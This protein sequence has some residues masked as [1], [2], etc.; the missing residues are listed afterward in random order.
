MKRSASPV[1]PGSTS[2][3]DAGPGFSDGG[4]TG[5]LDADRALD[6]MDGLLPVSDRGPLIAHLRQCPACECAFQGMV[7]DRERQRATLGVGLGF[8]QTPPVFDPAH[9]A[10]T[11]IDRFILTPIRR[12]G[13]ALRRPMVAVPA[14][15]AAVLLLVFL[16]SAHRPQPP[17]NLA[18][19][20]RLP[21]TTDGTKSLAVE[22]SASPSDLFAGLAAYDRGEYPQAIRLLDQA[23]SDGDQELFR[24]IYL[25][26]ALLRVGQTKQAAA[27]MG[28]TSI[29]SLLLLPEPW[30][31]GASLTAYHAYAGA[32]MVA[33]AEALRGRLIREGGAL[34]ELARGL[35]K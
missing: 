24:R 19:L 27:V 22:R 20:P 35:K 16:W 11:P 9:S 1:P 4:A 2:R 6:L 18:L 29:Q 34:E 12:A 30:R 26:N 14:G 33:Q 31:S 7:A 23:G 17:A 3:D 28:S 13:A 8:E 10:R 15:A 25:G 32:G 5:H 21:R